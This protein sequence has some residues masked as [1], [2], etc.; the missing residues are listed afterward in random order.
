VQDIPAND[1]YW[2]SFWELPESADDVFTL[3][4]A[5]D[6]RRTR[7]KHLEN[8]ETLILAITSRLFALRNHP[9]FP[10]PEAAPDREALNCIR[11]LTRLIPFI[12]ESEPLEGWEDKFFWG[13]RRKRLTRES[14]SSGGSEVIFDETNP[15]AAVPEEY[16]DAPPLMEE[17]VDCLIDLLFYQG[18]TLPPAA[19]SG[20]S[21]VT[22][23]IWQRYGC[24]LALVLDLTAG[25]LS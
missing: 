17:L 15:E 8:L 1:P 16:E 11:I 25:L 7:D 21:K 23:A 12:Y 13:V 6:I 24:P 5:A 19:G 10:D 18:F 9:A 3:F 2:L 4:S 22:Y 20:K 14:P